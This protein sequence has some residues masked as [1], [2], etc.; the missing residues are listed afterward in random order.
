MGVYNHKNCASSRRARSRRRSEPGHQGLRRG[1]ER[2]SGGSRIAPTSPPEARNSTQAS[3]A[4]G[5][6]HY[7]CLYTRSLN[8]IHS[9]LR[10]LFLHEITVLATSFRPPKLNRDP[11]GSARYPAAESRPAICPCRLWPGFA[12]GESLQ[13]NA[14]PMRSLFANFLVELL[15]ERVYS[16]MSKLNWGNTKF[17]LP[18]R[19]GSGDRR[20]VSRWP[21]M[22][23]SHC[24]WSARM[25]NVGEA[26]CWTG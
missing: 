2:A 14:G 13:N 15:S 24:E 3:V 20:Q 17:S 6:P 8:V 22:Y 4:I 21:G 9:D 23:E 7:A 25:D 26:V 12:L 18:S 11:A 16:G 10:R 5:E 1:D 19:C